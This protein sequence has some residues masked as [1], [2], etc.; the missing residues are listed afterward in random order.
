MTTPDPARATHRRWEDVPLERLK[1]GLTR[2]LV[3]GDGIMV[4]QIE[5]KAGEAVPYHAHE[6]E[7]VSYVLSGALRFWLGEQGEREVLVRAGE[8]LVIPPNV[9]HRVV[10]LEDTFDLDLFNPPRQDWLAGTD[11]YLRR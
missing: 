3:T 8:I 5:L 2:R 4:A 9:P 6:N 11:S 10:A 1:A 7:Q